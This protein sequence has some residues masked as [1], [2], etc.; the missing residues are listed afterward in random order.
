MTAIKAV[1]FCGN[2]FYIQRGTQGYCTFTENIPIELDGIVHNACHLPNQ[3]IDACYLFCI[4]FLSIF[5]GNLQDTFGNRK[6][7]H[8]IYR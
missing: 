5:Q 7:M 6:L 4:Y 2:A 3:E 1:H 8:L